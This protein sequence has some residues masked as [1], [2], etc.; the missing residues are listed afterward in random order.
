[1]LPQIK[2]A[3][4][5]AVLTYLEQLD[6]NGNGVFEF[7]ELL[8]GLRAVPCRTPLGLVP[9]APFKLKGSSLAGGRSGG[10]LNSSQ[11]SSDRY[12]AP[13]R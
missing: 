11:R 7:K 3:E 13:S 2:P 5:R 1:V 10:A 9:R 4:T 8:F 12:G 6:L